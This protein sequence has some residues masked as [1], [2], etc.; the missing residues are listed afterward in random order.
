MAT[1]KQIAA[2]KLFVKRVRAGEFAKGGK[3]K[4]N[5]T[6]STY[7]ASEKI[8][9]LARKHISTAIQESSA[10]LCLADAIAL[11]DKGE[12]DYAATRA[13]RSLA[14]SIGIFAGDYKKA[15][16]LLATSGQREK[17]PIGKLAIGSRVKFKNSVVRQSNHDKRVA[18]M[19]GVI[20]D[21]YSNGKV[22]SVD[23]GNTFLSEDGRNIRGIPLANLEPVAYREPNPAKRKAISRPSQITGAKPT[24]RLVARRRLPAKKGYFPNPV[25][26]EFKHAVMYYKSNTS[27]D[28]VTIA[29]FKSRPVAVS[30]AE[31]LASQNPKTRFAVKS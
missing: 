19:R 8:I 21:I 22:A 29:L 13:L 28:T 15:T 12:Y 18:D 9:K 11:F 23:T 27:P 30:Y 6:N 3:R 7:G 17:N 14:Y 16:T 2:R 26:S 31:A 25:N 10:R 1:A 4:R 24:K 20:V 5:P